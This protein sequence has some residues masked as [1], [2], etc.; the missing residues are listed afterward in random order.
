[1]ATPSK[2]EVVAVIEEKNEIADSVELAKSKGWDHDRLVGVIKSLEA[3]ER[4]TSTSKKL[5]G[6]KLTPEGEQYAEKG[7]PEVQVF[8]FVKSKEDGASKE[9]LDAA[10]G[11]VGKVGS[12]V[13][14]KNRW[15]AMD[16]GT[17]KFTAA[18][19]SVT[20]EVQADLKG[21]QDLAKD[22]V[23]ALKKRKM[24]AMTSTTTFRV[25][26][27]DKWGAAKTKAVAE[28]T[29]EMLLKGTWK[30]Q[31]FKP[32]NFTNASGLRAKGGAL[33][34]LM[35]VR[36]EI[37]NVLLLMGFEEM[38]T[39]QW[40]ESSFW[41]F[42]TLFQPQQHPARD[43]HDTFFIENPAAA[44]NLPADY[45]K[46]VKEMHEKGGRGSIGWRYDWSEDEAKKNLLRT[47][48]TSVSS[49]MLHKLAGEYK[50]TG[51]FTPRKYFSIDRV[52]RNETL[53]HTH[54]AEFHQV[55]GFIA[56]RNLGLGH[57]IGVLKEFFLRIGVT[58]LRFKPA[59]NPY[60]EPSMEIF[61][62]H[63]LLQKTVE[64]G[65]SGVFRPEMLLPMG[66][67]ED[68]TVVAW[69]IGLERTA[70]RMY[71]IKGIREL[72]SHEQDMAETRKKKMTWLKRAEE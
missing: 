15:V 45:L 30:D 4:A 33:H 71:N 9:D 20:D 36:A 16:K 47:H 25:M 50:K 43:A 10:L 54:L 27:T 52:F 66:L 5:E 49:R 37:R 8:N 64:L 26:K 57:L 58:Q 53:D 6:V 55:E 42:D 23:D 19:D 22:K 32:L 56:D 2:E 61:G 59:Y 18:V 29:Q 46:D 35:K 60:T 70:A 3:D 68:V 62:Y 39:N 38:P 11:E 40:V 34:P 48:T 1:M 17:K 7:S 41:N 21:L 44:Q 65:N 72:F 14:M 69:G 13:A 67:P 24:V 28:V 12:G 51:I 63:P 31:E